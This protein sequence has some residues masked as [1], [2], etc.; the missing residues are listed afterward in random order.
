MNSLWSNGISKF[1]Y[2]AREADCK[3][4]NAAN[5]YKK[6]AIAMMPMK[7]AVGYINLSGAT[8]TVN[9]NASDGSVA[10]QTGACEMGQGCLT[11]VISACASEFGISVD[12]VSAF[13]P[14]TSVL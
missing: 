8:V 13:Y 12:K 6:R 10:I 2:A 9:I 11:K 14:N 7:Y 4:F 5:K 3:A 1:N